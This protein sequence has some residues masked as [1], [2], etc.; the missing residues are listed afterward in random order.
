MKIRTKFVLPVKDGT[1]T[2]ENFVGDTP[3]M[4]SSDRRYSKEDHEALAALVEE[5]KESAK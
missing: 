4:G 5:L 2:D 1:L 3:A